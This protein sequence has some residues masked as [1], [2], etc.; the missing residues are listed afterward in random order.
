M[1]F[2]RF[3][4]LKSHARYSLCNIYIIYKQDSH[5]VY[6]LWSSHYGSKIIYNL[7]YSPLMKKF[8][9]PRTPLPRQFIYSNSPKYGFDCPCGR[10]LGRC[11]RQ[12]DIGTC[13]VQSKHRDLSKSRR[14][15]GNGMWLSPENHRWDSEFHAKNKL[16]DIYPLEHIIFYHTGGTILKQRTLEPIK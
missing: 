2:L 14:S 4:C 13:P 8:K 6:S 15:Q 3:L 1:F 7:K 11:S 12:A 9:G 10:I 16:T 5:P